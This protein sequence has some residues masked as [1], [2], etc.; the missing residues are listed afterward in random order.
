MASFLLLLK[1]PEY[2][3]GVW[4]FSPSP[5]CWLGLFLWCWCIAGV[6]PGLRC[7]LLCLQ[8]MM[9]IKIV[10]KNQKYPKVM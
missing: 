4:W 5:G 6:G 10:N 9:Q 2:D 3:P 1:D 8:I 7:V